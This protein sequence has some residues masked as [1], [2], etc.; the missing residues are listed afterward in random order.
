MAESRT[1]CFR[2]FIDACQVVL[3]A[4][5]IWAITQTT[6]ALRVSRESLL[7]A[8]K[9]AEGEQE[10]HR[11][12]R[13]WDIMPQVMFDQRETRV[14]TSISGQLDE[15]GFV[16]V[17]YAVNVGNGPAVDTS[18]EWEFNTPLAA[19]QTVTTTVMT[20]N[21]ILPQGKAQLKTLP[22]DLK[23]VDLSKSL[24]FSGVVTIRCQD[25]DKNIVKTRQPFK[26]T[27]LA[28]EKTKQVEWLIEFMFIKII[29]IDWV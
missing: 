2:L 20:P 22:F 13:K 8:K 5:A 3:A 25:M 29:E 1:S 7:I 6:E 26:I 10:R 17:G 19:A 18:L 14:V 11:E 21:I 27:V 12:S 28:D 23:G 24:E 4:C 15:S 16:T 9:Q